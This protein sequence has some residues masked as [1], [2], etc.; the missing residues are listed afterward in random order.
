MGDGAFMS[1][2]GLQFKQDLDE[3]FASLES[4]LVD[5][6]GPRISTMRN[7]RFAMVVYDTSEEFALR[8]KAN[9][10]SHKLEHKGWKVIS[11]S[12]QEMML[13]RLKD[14]GEKTLERLIQ[15]EKKL[16]ETDPE[17]AFNHVQ[18]KLSRILEGPD[19][20]AGD[21]TKKITEALADEPGN[22]DN[23]VVFLSRAGSLYPFMRMSALLKH[24]DGHTHNIPVILFYPGRRTEEGLSFMGVNPPDRD[25]RPRI[26]P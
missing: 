21:I 8:R 3:A 26:Y 5:D 10:L 7:Y 23:A 6:A 9:A 24:L 1:Q 13:Q 11:I 20:L 17:R 4:D 14:L 2:E 19:G 16:Y 12:L 25:Y 18:P 22:K 15:R